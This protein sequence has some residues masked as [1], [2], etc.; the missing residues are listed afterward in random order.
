ME[1]ERLRSQFSLLFKA[2]QLAAKAKAAVPLTSKSNSNIESLQLLLHTSWDWKS[3]V[4]NSRHREFQHIAGVTTLEFGIIEEYRMRLITSTP[5]AL[6]LRSVLAGALKKE[7][8]PG[9]FGA[10]TRDAKFRFA[11]RIDLPAHDTL[12]TFSIE[13]LLPRLEATQEWR[14]DEMA[15]QNLVKV[16]E[17]C[18]LSWRDPSNEDDSKSPPLDPQVE[19]VLVQ[20][21]KVGTIFSN[22][23]L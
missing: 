4:V 7:H 16:I 23:L 21:V 13:E 3:I 20:L 6:Y 8:R 11:D 14:S 10:P 12:P 19:A 15:V 17:R 22:I 9:I 1:L 2:M 18:P 5:G